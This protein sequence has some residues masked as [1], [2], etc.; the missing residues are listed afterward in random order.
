MIDTSG[1]YA[2]V[3]RH[4][5]KIRFEN[6]NGWLERCLATL[7][8]SV[9][10]QKIETLPLF[11]FPAT[12]RDAKEIER[13]F[14]SCVWGEPEHADYYQTAFPDALRHTTWLPFEL[15]TL[16][17]PSMA[18]FWIVDA[19]GNSFRQAF[20][21]SKPVSEDEPFSWTHIIFHKGVLCVNSDFIYRNW[22][23]EVSRDYESSPEV[24]SGFAEQPIPDYA[25]PLIQA[26]ISF[27]LP[28]HFVVE[29]ARPDQIAQGDKSERKG[30][31]RQLHQR[32]RYLCLPT[33]VIHRRQH[34]AA[35]VGEILARAP[36]CRRGHW[37]QLRHERYS[38]EKREKPQ[39]IKA[40][41][42][43]SEEWQEGQVRY[44]VRL[45]L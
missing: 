34:P 40:C 22:K 27:N 41:W 7:L 19:P 43:G 11:E 15:F 23:L 42:V 5:S 3:V 45:D 37:R 12:P 20:A 32:V 1:L 33:Q 18:D 8:A 21:I 24:C 39:W 28:N 10:Q 31:H 29:N 16:C 38:A 17:S 6:P 9:Q 13:L 36:H 26:L 30:Y 4:F 44:K 25:W 2:G 14:S 35:S